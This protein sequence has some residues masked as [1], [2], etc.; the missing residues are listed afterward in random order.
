VPSPL[1]AGATMPV[2]LRVQWTGGF[3]DF[4]QEK[5]VD[6]MARKSFI[7]PLMDGS[8]VSQLEEKAKT[9]TEARAQLEHMRAT[10]SGMGGPALKDGSVE[11][12]TDTTVTGG[13]WDEAAVLTG[14]TFAAVKKDVFMKMDLRLVGEP[15]V[16]ALVAKAMSRI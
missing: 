8:G 6:G 12:K 11:F 2:Y 1:R 14:F 5:E 10:V 9:D 15:K 16:K 4:G 13:S 7:G 3:Y